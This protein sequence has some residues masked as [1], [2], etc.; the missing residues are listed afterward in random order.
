MTEAADVA[1]R[2]LGL[3]DLTSL[4]DTDTEERIRALCARAVTPVG[5]VAAVCVYPRFVALS[6]AALAGTGVRVATV[7]NFP[8][9]G[10][11]AAAAADET[12][13]AVAA[14]ADEIDAV[15]PYQAFKAGNRAAAEAVLRAVRT[16]C[17][18]KTLKVIL[19]TGQLGDEAS[20]RAASEL[21]ADCG[22]DFLKTS[23]GKTKPAATPEAAR[24]MLGVIRARG[25]RIGFKAAGGIRDTATAAAYLALADAALG[26]GWATPA[27][28][29]F[30]A[31][32]LLDALLA[33]LGIGQGGPA[34]SY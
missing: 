34:T 20:M 5:R 11:S 4:E 13:D 18:D 15:L 33:D 24:V 12:R 23:T 1:R 27:N 6:K 22:A 7:V 9:G 19:E 32:G 2:A 28:F 25:G 26:A 16:A 29:R 21:A 3:L 8:E 17:G 30:G 10:E 14:G 31:S